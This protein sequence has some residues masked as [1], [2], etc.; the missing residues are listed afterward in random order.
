MNPIQQLLANLFADPYSTADFMHGPMALAQ[1][2]LPAVVIGV[3]GAAAEGMRELGVG[4]YLNALYRLERP[5]DR[6]ALR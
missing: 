4:E 5:L 1:R 2:S 3:R 6:R